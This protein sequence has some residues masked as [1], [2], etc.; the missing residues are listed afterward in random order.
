MYDGTMDSVLFEQWFEERLIPASNENSVFVMDNASFHRKSRLQ[1]ICAKYHRRI[2]F[3]PPYSPELNPI[4]KTWA[5]LK[6]RLRG[7]MHRY[8][9]L[10]EAICYIF[11]L[12]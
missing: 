10:E 2:V 6:K 11:S 9:T 3:L 8:N 5:R 1:E 7:I 4:E 12:I